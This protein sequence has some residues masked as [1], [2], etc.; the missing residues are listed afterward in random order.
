[1]NTFNIMFSIFDRK[2][3]STVLDIYCK[4][5]I[6]ANLVTLCNGTAVNE[7]LN[8]IG[9]E[10]TEKVMITSFITSDTW[11]SVSKVLKE[12]IRIDIP[13]NGIAFTVPLSGVGSK[14]QLQFLVGEQNFDYKEESVLQNTAYELLVVVSNIGYSNEVMDAARL[15]NARGGT[16][17]H[18]K[19]TGAKSAEKF[20]GITLGSEKEMIYIVIKSSNKVNVMNSIMEHARIES[21]AGSIIFSLPVTDTLGM[22]FAE[23]IEQE[24]SEG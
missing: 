4:N 12:S 1:M 11:K 21:P 10:K 19:G 8:Y 22:K 13:G 6:C 9:L 20:L 2:I 16:V 14:K 15:A 17:I 18:A 5:N 24:E 23:F 3:L 7:I